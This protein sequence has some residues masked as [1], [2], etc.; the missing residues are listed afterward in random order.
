MSTDPRPDT[1][2]T[3]TRTL[4]RIGVVLTLAVL[5]LGSVRFARYDWSGLPIERAPLQTER[6]VG[7]DCLEPIGTYTTES[8]R[9]VERVVI[10]EQQYMALVQLYRGV[11]VEDLQFVCLYDPFNYRSGVAWL[12]HWLPFDEALSLGVTNVALMVASVW[13]VLAALR[14]QGFGPRAVLAAGTLFAVAWNTFYFGSGLLVETGV[15]FGVSLGWYLLS[16]R[17]PWF[18]VP[19]VFLAFP[20][21]E[22]VGVLVPVMFAMAWQRHRRDREP[23]APLLAPAIAALAAFLAAIVVWRG[24]AMPRADASWEVTID[25]DDIINNLTD[26]VSLASFVIGVGPLLVPSFLRLRRLA[27]EEGWWPALL[28]PAVVGVAL[29]LGIC[30]WSF[31]TVDLTPRLFWMGFPFAATLTAQWFSSGRPRE[32]LERAPVPAALVR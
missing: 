27:A 26:V 25:L 2:T 28:D 3:S 7:P 8:G 23:L 1:P 20:L 9:V 12:A 6:Q 15:L 19:L 18:V 13:L 4:L 32:W 5:L 21:K 10:D 22:T 14:R 31:L 17:K 24:F 11:P 30:G 16:I 29:A